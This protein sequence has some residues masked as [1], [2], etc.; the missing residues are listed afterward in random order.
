MQAINKPIPPKSE[1]QCHFEADLDPDNLHLQYLKVN[2]LPPWSARGASGAES[3]IRVRTVNDR[4]MNIRL[5]G[6]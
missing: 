5:V 1:Q 6:E 3:E 2:P 4:W